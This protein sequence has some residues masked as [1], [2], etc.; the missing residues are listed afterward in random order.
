MAECSTR[1][2]ELT[3]QLERER[4]AHRDELA[5]VMSERQVDQP[6]GDETVAG[7]LLSAGADVWASLMALVCWP[8]FVH[9]LLHSWCEPQDAVATDDL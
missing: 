5:K 1:L 9:S 3:D 4:L 2:R 8:S 7:R 6:G